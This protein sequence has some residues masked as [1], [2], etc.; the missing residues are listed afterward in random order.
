MGL[1]CVGCKTAGALALEIAMAGMT[2]GMW[3]PHSRAF[4][5]FSKFSPNVQQNTA[6]LVFQT[7]LANIYK[8]HWQGP[9]AENSAWIQHQYWSDTVPSHELE[10]N[11]TRIASSTL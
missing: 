9:S 5:L 3:S 10:D 7:F 11:M 8:A 1:G 4:L 2:P 6:A